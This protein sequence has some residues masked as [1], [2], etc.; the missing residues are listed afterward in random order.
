MYERG[1]YGMACYPFR[2]TGSAG[3][4][5]T[6]EFGRR[7]EAPVRHRL[8]PPSFRI[9]RTILFALTIAGSGVVPT[10][11]GSHLTPAQTETAVAL[12]P[13]HTARTAGP[14]LPASRLDLPA[15]RSFPPSADW[16]TYEHDDERS[17]DAINETVLSPVVAKNLSVVASVSVPINASVTGSQSSIAG[18]VAVADGVVYAGSWNGALYAF[19]AANLTKLWSIQLTNPRLPGAATNV[20]RCWRLGGIGSTP[21]VL[22]G[23]GTA[24]S[25]VVIAAG[26]GIYA[27]NASL[28]PG[29]TTPTIRWFT[30][31]TN[32]SF[33]PAGA[34][35]WGYA[36]LWGTPLVY[37]GYVYMGV[38]S[39]CDQRFVQ[40]QVF[41]IPVTGEGRYHRP[42]HIFNVTGYTNST[43]D[44]A[45]GVWSDPMVDPSTGTLWVTTGNE[46]GTWSGCAG[47]KYVRAILGLN[48]SNVSELRS[49]FQIPQASC[50]DPTGI[51]PDE[52]FGAGATL[53]Y[54]AAGTPFAGASNKDG[55]FF[56]ANATDGAAAWNC[57]I[58]AS[59]FTPLSPA[60]W[61][62]TTLFVAGDGVGGQTSGEIYA[63]TPQPSSCSGMRAFNAT[64]GGVALGG[65]TYANGLLVVAYNEG[66]GAGAGVLAVYDAATGQ[67]L[68][69]FTESSSIN[70]E[71]VVSDGRIY[72]GVGNA[73]TADTGSIVALGLPFRIDPTAGTVN[74]T[75]S[76]F[77]FEAG[78]SG[79][80]PNYEYEWSFGDGSANSSTENPVHQYGAV[81]NYTVTVTVT[82]Y[83]GNKLV[84]HLTASVTEVAG[85]EISRDPV[86]L[87]AIAWL[88]VT[89]PSANPVSLEWGGL[90][91]GCATENTSSLSCQPEQEGGFLVT[92]NWTNTTGAA[93][94]IPLPKLTV[95]PPLTAAVNVTPTIGAPNLT[96]EYRAVFSGGTPPYQARWT[97]GAAGRS[98][99][100]NGSAMLGG[101]GPYL[102]EFNGSDGGG[103]TVH[104]A[105]SVTVVRAFEVASTLP[106]LGGEVGRP[107]NLTVTSQGG[108]GPFSVEWVG[109]P[110]GCDSSDS[111]TIECVPTSPGVYPVEA[112]AVDALGEQSQATLTVDVAVGITLA[113]LSE[114]VH[115]PACSGTFAIPLRPVVSGGEP[116]YSY[117]WTGPDLP[118][119]SSAAQP[120]TNL[121]IG[122]P[123][124]FNLTVTDSAGGAAQASLTL[125]VLGPSCT[126]LHAAAPSWELPVVLGSV[127]AVAVVVL[128]VLA[129]RRHYRRPR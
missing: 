99:L 58:G 82:D 86:D 46:N 87:G 105:V 2:G 115:S 59:I 70:G 104:G 4:I 122:G 17:G 128:A 1:S 5:S 72:F 64:A 7:T 27:V 50:Y 24:G 98:G 90:P 94:T 13:G 26:T 41:Q 22:T 77:Q 44:V 78:A 68:A 57:T 113:N 35:N 43:G 39:A 114:V 91:P 18:S 67:E 60:A 12:S 19:N 38:A 14:L 29:Q 97:F 124:T 79:G 31:L 112:D 28:A 84:S 75:E 83:A 93:G 88:N 116:P 36:D 125:Q 107:L 118:G 73:Y 129:V 96:I 23:P 71:P 10:L 102:V 32:Y 76:L 8:N 30:N 65:L 6:K 51:G 119:G 69:S 48:A 9:V 33:V 81:G 110:T 126:P 53:F 16:L 85:G 54:D 45:G 47:Q 103:G 106:F 80:M 11:L 49:V 52:D 123:Y 62:G 66:S 121:G 55:T 120:A 127:A 42:A 117:R 111:L 100:S 25:T 34:K 63:I 3:D 109:L 37:D 61:N 74:Q 108:L 56:V 15:P 95:D 21:A 92:A 89:V 40:G 101:P 20:S